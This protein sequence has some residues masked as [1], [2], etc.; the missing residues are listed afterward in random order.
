MWQIVTSSHINTDNL[1]CDVL[2][3]IE[4]F[5]EVAIEEELSQTSS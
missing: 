5:W 4:C 3:L 2:T 1:P